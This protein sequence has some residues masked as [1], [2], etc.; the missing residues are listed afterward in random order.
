MIG[1][2]ISSYDENPRKTA[3]HKISDQ[4]R[5][6]MISFFLYSWDRP[7]DGYKTVEETCGVFV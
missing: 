1:L 5:K 4:Y 6:S 2:P 3:C 7:D